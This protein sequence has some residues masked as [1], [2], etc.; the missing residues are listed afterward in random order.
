MGDGGAQCCFSRWQRLFTGC[1][2][3]LCRLLPFLGLRAWLEHLW[4]GSYKFA[5][6]SCAPQHPQTPIALPVPPTVQWEL[7]A[8]NTEKRGQGWVSSSDV[9]PGFSLEPGMEDRLCSCWPREAEF[10][11]AF[12]RRKK[13]TLQTSDQSRCVLILKTEDLREQVD[14]LKKKRKRYGSVSGEKQPSIST[15]RKHLLKV[16]VNRML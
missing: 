6:I 7:G 12:Q 2:F 11:L 14:I 8:I 10:L 16:R 4:I 5:S 3:F 1:I 15:D 9:L 13:V